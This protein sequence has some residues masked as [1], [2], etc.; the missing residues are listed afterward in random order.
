[1]SG[2]DDAALVQ[3]LLIA[4][5]CN[6]VCLASDAARSLAAPSVAGGTTTAATTDTG[7]APVAFAVHNSIAL[8]DPESKDYRGIEDVLVGHTGRVNAVQ[9]IRRGHGAEQRDVGLVSAGVDQT[10]RIWKRTWT[11][12]KLLWVM[13]ATLNGHTAPITA[14]GVSRGRDIPGN[15]DIIVSGSSDGTIRVWERTESDGIQ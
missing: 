4:G 10:L 5:A 11:G 13:S 1:M 6:R 14:L 3:P 2:D 8:F 9:F 15:T 12:N 7:G